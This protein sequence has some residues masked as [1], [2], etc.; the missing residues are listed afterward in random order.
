MTITLGEAIWASVKPIIKIYLIIAT[1]IVLS[2][3][4]L[5]SVETTR[6]I[7][8][9]VLAVLLPCL[10][11]NKIVGSLEARDAKTV[12]IVAISAV[13]VYATGLGA[14]LIVSSLLPCPPE[15]K[16]GIL[17]GGMFP[18]IS[19]LPIAYLQTMDTFVF[20][21]EEGARGIACAIIFL[22]TFLLCVFNL[23]GFRLIEHDFKYADVESQSITPSLEI[24]PSYMKDEQRTRDSDRSTLTSVP[25]L[26]EEESSQ[27]SM[28][29]LDTQRA[30]LAP[31]HTRS[32]IA[33]TAISSLPSVS[34]FS[35]MTQSSVQAYGD[36]D[37]NYTND[38]RSSNLSNCPSC[39]AAAA[40]S[41]TSS[42]SFSSASGLRNRADS[43]N[44]LHSVRSIDQRTTMPIQGLPEMI[45]EYSNVDQFGKERRPSSASAFST[46]TMY[47]EGT[48]SEYSM[49]EKT[50]KK[51]PI[52][53]RIRSSR[54]TR[55]VTSDATVNKH[56]IDISGESVLPRMIIKIPGSH[57]LMFFLTNCLRPCSVA[58]FAGLFIAF[59]PWLK[60]LFVTS[61]HTPYVG[62]APDNQPVLSFIMDYTG[63]LG[64]ASVPFGLLLLG[65]TLGRLQIS[66]LYPGFWKT[67]TLLV[68]LK[69]CI[70]PIFG[71]LWCDRLVKAGW[72][73]WE[74]DKML[75][76]VIAMTWGLPTM[77]TLIYFTASYTPAD[78][79]EHIQIDCTSFFIVLQ[80]P[81]LIISL[82]F[83]VT[84]MLMVQLKV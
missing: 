16:G 52:M 61:N 15:W 38:G 29:T 62:L 10:A 26:Q 17:A 81:L 44:T 42:S 70:M 60:A 54:L 69:L 73:T 78:A 48:G 36:D 3:L 12:G 58:V 22:T 41:R 68:F 2:R 37:D 71:V 40:A 21:E 7:S 19:D 8:D 67:A 84:Y 20:T 11:F 49:E 53:D 24:S 1:G 83:L 59:M 27:G 64:A 77:T 13:L 5:L 4:A 66:S 56:D 35:T 74:D 31:T 46:T 55:M 82:P 79:E 9:V 34:T 76:F 65:A 30:S 72:C 50:G 23:G 63:Y 14:A 6:A 57:L 18:N 32:S 25:E 28:Y 47:S 75:L 43:M 51:L 39:L 33:P 80:Y 45:Y